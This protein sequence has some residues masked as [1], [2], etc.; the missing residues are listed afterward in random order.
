MLLGKLMFSGAI[1]ELEEEEAPLVTPER[2]QEVDSSQE[3]LSTVGGLPVI[4]CRGSY[5]VLTSHKDTI[6]CPSVVL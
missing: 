2:K 3:V 6:L 1:T 4:I 5:L